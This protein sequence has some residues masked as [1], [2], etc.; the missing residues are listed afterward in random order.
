MKMYKEDHLEPP[1]WVMLPQSRNE[2]GKKKSLASMLGFK[3]RG[4]FYVETANE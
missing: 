3:S 4:G 2:Q 1:S